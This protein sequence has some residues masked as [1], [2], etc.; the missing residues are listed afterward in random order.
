MKRIYAI[1]IAL[2]AGFAAPAQVKSTLVFRQVWFGYFNQTRLSQRWGFWLDGQYR[3]REGWLSGLNQWAIR[4]G[5]MYHFSERTALTV[6]Y[7]YFHNEPL[8][9]TRT[10]AQPEHRPWQQIQWAHGP[11]QQTFRLE[12]RFRRNYASDSTLAAD[13]QFY[14]RARYNFLYSIPLHGRW[15]STHKA[16]VIL[17][18]ELC[19]NFGRQI[20]YNYFDQNRFFAGFRFRV[21]PNGSLQAG[22][23][24]QFQQLSSG[25][26]YRTIHAIRLSYLHQ[27]DLRKHLPS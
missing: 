4:P 18:D 22:Y 15:L 27:I 11:V 19:I 8:D 10:V 17:N 21:N 13:H 23:M 20:V 25:R 12:E 7:A 9:G 26:Q 16:A 3:T 14:Y 2:L 24:N 5:I 1:S 6:G